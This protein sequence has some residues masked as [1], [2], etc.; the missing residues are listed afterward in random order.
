MTRATRYLDRLRVEY[1]AMFDRLMRQLGSEDA[2]LRTIDIHAG[3]W[4]RLLKMHGP[5]REVLGEDED[6]SEAVAGSSGV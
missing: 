6:A 5:L 4:A 2:L 3:H 1:P